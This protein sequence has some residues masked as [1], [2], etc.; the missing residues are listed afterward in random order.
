M[1]QPKIFISYSWSP[2]SNKQKVLQL[3]ERLT[4]NGVH[5]VIDEWD[6]KAGQDKF[7]FMEQMVT[8]SSVEKVL[9]IC[10]KKYAEKANE[11]KGGVGVEGTIISKQVYEDAKQTKFLPVIFEYDEEG[12]AY[13]PT[14]VA[15]AIYFDLS[16]DNIFEEEYDKLL[17]DLFNKPKS[18]RPPIGKIPLYLEDEDPKYLPTANRV[19]VI[20]NA[21]LN[22]NQS[23][24]LLIKDYLRT[25]IDSL[26]SY[27]LD[28]KILNNDNF[29]YEVEKSINEMLPLKE[30]FLEFVMAIVNTKFCTGELFVDLFER[31]LQTYEDNDISLLSSESI[32]DLANDNYRYFNH[33]IFLSFCTTLIANECYDV[34]SDVIKANFIVTSKRFGN[35]EVRR[36]VYF[37]KYNYTLNQHKNKR[38]RLN[39]VSVNADKIKENAKSVSSKDIITIDILLYYLSLIFKIEGGFDSYWFPETSCYHGGFEILPKLISKRY[40]NKIKALFGVDTITEYKTLVTGVVE[41]NIRDGFYYRIPNI[42]IGLLI[43]KVG[44][45]D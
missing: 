39:R 22:D 21:I 15:S 38:E 25:F 1:H 44:T 40:F 18:K 30:D 7:A 10:S 28:Y 26:M 13:I 32:N 19:R 42:R 9:L 2:E 31:M 3:A 27:K 35:T 37:Q 12:K 16:N 11:R 17:R 45:V 29:I 24:S 4:S 20:K 33:D 41:P 34:C 5:V 23:V 14:F 43:D 6:L 8:D 36:F